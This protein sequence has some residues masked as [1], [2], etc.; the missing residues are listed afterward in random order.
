MLPDNGISLSNEKE[1]LMHITTLIIKLGW[2]K[3]ARHKKV[4]LYDSIYT[5]F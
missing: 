1:L 2:A 3:E 4:E 5:K